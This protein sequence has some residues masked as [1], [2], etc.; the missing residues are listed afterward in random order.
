MLDKIERYKTLRAELDNLEKDLKPTSV[1]F[2]F[3]RAIAQDTR[4]AEEWGLL[5]DQETWESSR[6]FTEQMEIR[7]WAFTEQGIYSVWTWENH[8]GHTD[9]ITF[10]TPLV[11]LTDPLALDALEEKVKDHIAALN[12]RLK[13]EAEAR[14]QRIIAQA[15][16]ERRARYEELKREFGDQ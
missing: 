13:A 8:D 12:A 9:E 15:T 5:D 14:R 6:C 4:A 11:Y 16:A 1:A 7:H 2:R 10:T 3:M